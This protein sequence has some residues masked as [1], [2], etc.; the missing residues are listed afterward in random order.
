MREPVTETE[1]LQARTSARALAVVALLVLGGC[2]SVPTAPEDRD[3]GDPFEPVNR[4]VFAFNQAVDRAVVRP[5][6]RGYDRVVPRPVKSSVTNVLDNLNTPIWAL[7]HLLQGQFA[8]AGRQAT[9]FV[10]N[11]TFGVL[12]IWDPA[13]GAGIERSRANFNQTFGRWG[14]PAGPYLVLPLLGPSSVRG[15]GALYVR[16][17]TDVTW[18][19]FDDNRSVRD[20]LIALEIIDTRR[21]L[22]PLDRTIRKAH[23]PY[24]F[25]RDAYRQRIEFEIRGHAG[26]PD[27]DFDFDDFDDFEEG[28]ALDDPG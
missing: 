15:V 23:D 17:Q 22:L 5:V 18:N 10:L 16:S 27:D 24:I 20:K 2:A 7:N 3:P 21:R 8:E 19:Y 11:T 1:A 28:E 25:V 4:Q 26:F 6:A 14:V 9:R 12:G 13:G